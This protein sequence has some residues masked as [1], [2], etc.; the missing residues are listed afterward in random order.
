MIPFINNLYNFNLF[1]LECLLLDD[2]YNLIKNIYYYKELPKNDSRIAIYGFGPFGESC[3]LDL[4][5]R[6]VIVAIY[7]VYF[8]KKYSKVKSPDL[9]NCSDFEYII[10]T[11][12]NGAAREQIE[13]FLLRKGVVSEQIIYLEYKYELKLQSLKNRH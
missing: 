13:T 9:I 7:D 2:R 12:M 6:N 8:C 4:F 5:S 10:I 1:Y 11:V 3:F